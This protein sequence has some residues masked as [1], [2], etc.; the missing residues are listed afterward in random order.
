MDY[1]SFIDD[2]GSGGSVLSSQLQLS[3]TQSLVQ[4]HKK[5]SLS[6][7][8]VKRTLIGLLMPGN[9]PD[10]EAHVESP[11]Q[12]VL[13]DEKDQVMKHNAVWKETWMIHA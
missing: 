2:C 10:R 6:M 4:S 1:V 5:S 8:A 7:E 11:F 9:H 3:V 13:Y 12:V